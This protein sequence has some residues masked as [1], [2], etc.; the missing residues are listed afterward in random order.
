M[1]LICTLLIGGVLANCTPADESINIPL[2]A[3]ETMRVSVSPNIT[4]E[5]LIPTVTPLVTTSPAPFLTS[6]P[7]LDSEVAYRTLRNYLTNMKPCQLPCWWGLSPGKSTL[8][9]V[10]KQLT[11]FSG[12]SRRVYFGQAGNSWTVGN[13]DID[14]DEG[15]SV[16]GVRTSY[17]IS[18]DNSETVSIMGIDTVSLP[19]STNG[20]VYGDKNYNELLFAYTL[21]QIVSTYG[22]P[23]QT[24]ITAEIYEAEPTAPDYF[25]IRL[26]YPDLG[27][28]IRYRMPAETNDS[29]YR[30]CP[31]LSVVYL[32]LIPKEQGN[33]YKD[34]FMQIGS[35]EWNPAVSEI[36]FYKS[37]DEAIGIT[38]EEFYPLITSSPTICFESPISIWPRP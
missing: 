22:I 4:T 23:A 33:S 19:Q 29:I 16:I 8:S 24:F 12:I 9:E 28:F 11:E 5:T 36:P 35:A 20:R 30:F 15:D 31:S 7:T 21:P 14:F 2:T 27:M 26:L 37:T 25:V 10:Q 34:Y 13:L 1:F 17:L 18:S 32:D 3:T 6:A 38:N